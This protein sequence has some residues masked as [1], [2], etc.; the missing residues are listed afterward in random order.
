MII[1]LKKVFKKYRHLTSGQLTSSR[2]TW[3]Q[4]VYE[5]CPTASPLCGAVLPFYDFYFTH[6]TTFKLKK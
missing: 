3:N 4:F 5:K 6:E 1:F 2:N